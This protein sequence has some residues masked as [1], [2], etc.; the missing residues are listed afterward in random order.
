MKRI[1]IIILTFGLLFQ[2]CERRSINKDIQLF[3]SKL[4]AENL[5]ILNELVK[6]F[7][8]YLETIFPLESSLDSSYKQFLMMTCLP[9]SWVE[10]ESDSMFYQKLNEIYSSSNLEREI[11]LKPETIKL[12]EDESS[13]LRIFKYNNI[14]KGLIEII[15]DTFRLPPNPKN[16][17]LTQIDFSVFLEKKNQ[18]KLFN[19]FGEFFQGL[20][21]IENKNDFIESY[22]V[23]K[24]NVLNY[25]GRNRYN[26]F[27]NFSMI[28]CGL[29]NSNVD[30]TDYFIK[31]IIIIEL[32]N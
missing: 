20:N 29:I 2:S 24:S 13:L 8:N 16:I 4:S 7:D 26:G 15:Q 28:A 5:K 18:L 14:Q 1:I 25:T 23:N 6:E 9:D 11:V 10:H 30:L 21:N 31:R 22:L 27:T 17:D 32:L 3:E 12:S 19:V